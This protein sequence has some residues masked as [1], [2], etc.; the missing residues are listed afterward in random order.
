MRESVSS[1]AAPFNVAQVKP[2][3]EP[4]TIAHQF[5]I[6]VAA[7]IKNFRSPYKDLSHTIEV[8]NP[9]D[10]RARGPE[11]TEAKKA[12]V[13]GL[14]ERETF[15]V[16]LREEVSPD[17]NVSLGSFFLSL[18]SRINGKTKYKARHVIKGNSDNMKQILLFSSVI[19]QLLSISLILGSAAIFGV[20][21]W[22][23]DIIQEYLRSTEPLARDIF[24]NKPAPEFEAS[25]DQCLKLL[26]PL[27][28]LC[29]AEDL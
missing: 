24:I 2:Y 28:G 22:T 17:S 5:L 13:R 29:D 21:L 11:M 4:V 6:D 25:P 19:P 26:R 15:R 20:D 8:L 16:T 23:A 27:Y 9:S 14:L 1:P 7:E 18:K 10:D 12:Q 3:F